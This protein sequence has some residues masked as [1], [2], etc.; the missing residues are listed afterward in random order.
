V[1]VLGRTDAGKSTLT[2]WLTDELAQSGPVAL[3]DADPGQGTTGPPTTIGVSF[4]GAECASS[5]WSRRLW[6]VG[7][8]NPVRH[9]LQML[10]GMRRLADY[11]ASRSG[12]MVVDSCGLLGDDLGRELHLESMELLAADVVVPLGPVPENAGLPQALRFGPW[13]LKRLRRSAARREKRRTER[14][15]RRE[16]AF[17]QAFT[18]AR[19]CTISREAAAFRGREVRVDDRIEGQALGLCRA[20]GSL[21]ALARG[22]GADES[23][24]RVWTSLEDASEIGFVRFGAGRVPIGP[25]T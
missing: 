4:A 20:D 23:A 13:T 7:D 9:M 19:E 24:I 11:A 18:E 22:L 5:T 25:D 17:R 2:H 14:R 3:L 12:C 21:L 15:Q 8:T 1:Y 6:F 16:E 10:T